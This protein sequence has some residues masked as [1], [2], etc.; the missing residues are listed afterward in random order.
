[1]FVQ[2]TDGK[3]YKNPFIA[4]NDDAYI[5][6]PDF[7]KPTIAIS[8]RR[9][10]E[11]KK[12]MTFAKIAESGHAD[13]RPFPPLWIGSRDCRCYDVHI[14]SP[15]PIELICEH[16]KLESLDEL[17]VKTINFGIEVIA[18]HLTFSREELASLYQG[19]TKCRALFGNIT[20]RSIRDNIR[21]H[22]KSDASF[23]TVH[24]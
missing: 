20:L 4:V 1:M 12:Q 13:K 19:R 15:V 9:K 14:I 10:T 5:Y 16:Y 24:R 17:F 18:F 8:K 7:G 21:D 23:I 22:V 11:T 2:S 6:F 3:F